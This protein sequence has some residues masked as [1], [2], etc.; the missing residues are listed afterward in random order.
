MHGALSTPSALAR[1]RLTKLMYDGV[2]YWA[3]PDLRA[4]Y[5][6]LGRAPMTA[7]NRNFYLR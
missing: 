7:S 3:L 1:F 2:E 4:L 5:E 6:Q